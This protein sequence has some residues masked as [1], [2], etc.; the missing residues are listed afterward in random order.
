[1]AAADDYRDAVRRDVR[2]ALIS[3][4][5]MVLATAVLVLWLTEVLGRPWRGAS[6]GLGLAAFVISI[7]AW[8]RGDRRV[9]ARRFVLGPG[10]LSVPVVA[11]S[12]PPIAALAFSTTA[13]L[14]ATWAWALSRPRS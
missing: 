9:T 12:M 4:V 3:S 5:L 13:A 14:L 1:M 6:L 10:L 2:S 11:L 8:G 7:G